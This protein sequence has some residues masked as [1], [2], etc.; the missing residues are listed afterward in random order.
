MHYIT[1]MPRDRVQI[2]LKEDT[3][4]IANLLKSYD[5]GAALEFEF[6]IMTTN[7]FTAKNGCGS[8]IDIPRCDMN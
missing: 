4:A 6:H 2:L 5:N 8:V 3:I 7:G 1:C